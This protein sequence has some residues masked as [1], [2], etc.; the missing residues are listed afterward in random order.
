MKQV[1]E[2]GN[3]IAPAYAG[4]LLAEQGYSVQ[5]WINDKDPILSLNEGD[6]IWKWI[7]HKK[8][9]I[10]KSVYQHINDIGNFEI[11]IDN[12]KP[13]TLQKWNIDPDAIALNHNLV[14]VSLRS[15]VDEISFD[16]LAQCRS[17][18][19]YCDWIPFYIGDTTAGLWMAFKAI[20]SSPGHYQIGH[21][22]CL[23]K[24]VEG[25]LILNPVRDKKSVPWD[26]E[27]YKMHSG[28][29]LIQYKEQVITETIKN[30]DWKL[31][32]LW[33]DRGRIII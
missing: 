1:L 32:H 7:N 6:S 26:K 9:L 2:L 8:E 16:L 22:S 15:E 31:K 27:S 3:Y 13:S 24:L 5:K 23:Q 25:E 29:A 10:N 4:M 33:H 20:C 12:F 11:V 30:R 28:A 14:W 17:W 19:E 21:A 18:L